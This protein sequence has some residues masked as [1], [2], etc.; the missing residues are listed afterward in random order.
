MSRIY[1]MLRS[2]DSSKEDAQNPWPNLED[3]LPGATVSPKPPAGKKKSPAGKEKSPSGKEKSPSGKEKSP[4]GKE[5]SPSGKTSSPT[6]KTAF[7][8]WEAT[9]T[10]RLDADSCGD[11]PAE[12][13]AN[14]HL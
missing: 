7:Q 10:Y 3:Q 6:G 9:A 1:I 13:Q 2:Y 8:G 4:S 12:T 5:E 11:T 14:R